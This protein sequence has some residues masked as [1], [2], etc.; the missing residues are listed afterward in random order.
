MFTRDPRP[1]VEVVPIND[2][3]ADGIGS[4]E[5]LGDCFRTI[6]FTFSWPLDGGAIE[7]VVVAKIVRPKK[8]I[9]RP[10]GAIIQWM[11]REAQDRQ[12][13]GLGRLH[14]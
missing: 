11:A 4:V 14:S 10:D 6:Y 8:S 13:S 9:L 5:N 12:M 2:I 7:R 1:L 3:Y